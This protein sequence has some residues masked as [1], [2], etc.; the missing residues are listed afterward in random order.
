MMNG[1]GYG[2]AG[3]AAGWIRRVL[4][5]STTRVIDEF[6]TGDTIE[7]WYYFGVEVFAG[8]EGGGH[9][10]GADNVVALARLHD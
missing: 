5:F 1:S 10:L 9:A 3:S 2:V 8:Q 4:P 7:F 6:N